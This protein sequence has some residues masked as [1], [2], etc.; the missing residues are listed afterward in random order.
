MAMFLPVTFMIK[1]SDFM[2]I[3]FDPNIL[4]SILTTWL[5]LHSLPFQIE[6]GGV[7]YASVDHTEF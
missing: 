7:M 5:W 4:L 1:N 6:G 3:T 2:E